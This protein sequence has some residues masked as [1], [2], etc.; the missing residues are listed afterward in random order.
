MVL[1]TGVRHDGSEG[2]GSLAH[3]VIGR[4]SIDNFG[5][6]GHA[7]DENALEPCFQ[8]HGGGGAR[9]TRTDE[10]DGDETGL[11][12]D[13][14]EQNVSIVGLDRRTD[15]FD[16]FLHLFAHVSSVRTR[17]THATLGRSTGPLTPRHARLG[18]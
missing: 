3:D 16:D 9:N 14:V 6:S 10:F 4:A 17:V 1:T 7:V 18:A 12:I 15:D 8:G 13:I 11:L 2:D 5:D